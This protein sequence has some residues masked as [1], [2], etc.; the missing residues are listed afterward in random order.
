[1]KS[2]TELKWVNINYNHINEFCRGYS[3]NAE[4]ELTVHLTSASLNIFETI[5]L[6]NCNNRKNANQVLSRN[7]LIY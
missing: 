5:S 1:M 7:L 6:K 4:N 2:N 3:E